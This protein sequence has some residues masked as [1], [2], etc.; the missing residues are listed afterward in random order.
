MVVPATASCFAVGTHLK[1]LGNEVCKAQGQIAQ[2]KGSQLGVGE[3]MEFEHARNLDTA[4]LAIL[5]IAW[6]VTSI[7][8]GGRIYSRH[9]PCN[10]SRESNFAAYASRRERHSLAR[11]RPAEAPV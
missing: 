11:C 9:A 3:A 5:S 2:R 10:T 8:T 4:T 1:V 6:H 7:R